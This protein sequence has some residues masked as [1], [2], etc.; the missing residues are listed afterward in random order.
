MK[1]F[2]Q[3]NVVHQN[4]RRPE[5]GTSYIIDPPDDHLLR[6]RDDVNFNP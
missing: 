4:S 5:V 2:K 6:P 1:T 3:K